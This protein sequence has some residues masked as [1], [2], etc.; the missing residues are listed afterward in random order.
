MI[1]PCVNSFLL[2]I[3]VSLLV[4]TFGVIVPSMCAAN[5]GVSSNISAE[6][7]STE[8]IGTEN[9]GSENI[10]AGKSSIQNPVAQ[11][12]SI[13]Q[14]SPFRESPLLQT[15]S[16][17]TT[18]Y[19]GNSALMGGDHMMKVLAALFL[20]LMLIAGASWVI[21]RLNGGVITANSLIKVLASYPMGAKQRIVL[22]EVNHTCLLLG[23]GTEQVSCLHEFKKGEIEPDQIAANQF[24][25]KLQEIL[26]KGVFK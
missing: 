6:N 3:L 18:P 17:Q 7:I 11:T 16:Y 2:K 14:Q 13:P 25:H 24:S 1:K 12:S 4:A 15:S 10:S 20:I 5:E 23:V 9:I 26:S 19:G 22:V 8:D 21:K